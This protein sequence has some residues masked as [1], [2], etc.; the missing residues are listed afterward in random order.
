MGADGAPPPVRQNGR[1]SL[2]HGH[3]CP[4]TW[5]G[6]APSCPPAVEPQAGPMD[7]P[8]GALHEVAQMAQLPEGQVQGP[9]SRVQGQAQLPEGQVQSI[10]VN[11]SLESSVGL[12]TRAILAAAAADGSVWLHEVSAEESS[13]AE[14][15][16]AESSPPRQ[17]ASVL[18]TPLAATGPRAATR[19]SPYVWGQGVCAG[20]LFFSRD[21]QI[22]CIETPARPR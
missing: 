12:G 13:P 2:L 8:A 15:S 14:S 7:P 21:G 11:S 1:A 17:A 22:C 5:M 9:G 19:D 6:F 20:R 18:E 4:I 3:T 10:P 16:P